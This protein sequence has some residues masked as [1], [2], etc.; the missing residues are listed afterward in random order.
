VSAKPETEK[1]DQ[2]PN[3][4][5]PAVTKGG[6]SAHDVTRL[7]WD[8]KET[9]DP[10]ALGR[11]PSP[12]DQTVAVFSSTEQTIAQPHSS[13]GAGAADSSGPGSGSAPKYG[14]DTSKVTPDGPTVIMAAD[15]GRGA[16]S[17]ADESLVSRSTSSI[18]VGKQTILIP[19]DADKVGPYTI[20]EEIARGGMG[21]V[22][23]VYREEL[24]KIF[25]LKVLLSGENASADSLTRFRREAQAAAKLD[26]HPNIVQVFDA[27]EENDIV[28]FTMD[29]IE[30]CSL[31]DAVRMDD[32]EADH[33]MSPGRAAEIMSQMARA[34]DYAHNADIIHRD[35][36][37][38]N[39]LLDRDYK[40]YLTDF[41]LAKDLDEAGDLTLPGSVLGSPPFMSPEQARGD[42][43][44]IDWRSDIYSLGA[45]LYFALCKKPPFEHDTILQ[46][47][48]AVAED[49]V[50]RLRS[51]VPGLHQDLETI[52]LKAMDREPEGRYET[53]LDFALDLEAFLDGRAISA[54]PIGRF[55]KARRYLQKH[56]ELLAM[57][58]VL[59]AL[60]SALT[61]NHWT[62]KATLE[63]NTEPKGATLFVDGQAV[64]TTPVRDLKLSPGRHELRAVRAGFREVNLGRHD[65]RRSEK[66][67]LKIPLVSSNGTLVV[68][69][70]PSAVQLRIGR[71]DEGGRVRWTKQSQS[72]YFE[73]LP[74][75]SGYIVE[76]FAL[77][78]RTVRSESFTLKYGRE[79]R[80]LTL[81]LPPDHGTLEIEGRPKNAP[82][83]IH[84]I[85]APSAAT[86]SLGHPLGD[87][88]CPP[89]FVTITPL[90][91]SLPLSLP[92]GVYEAVAKSPGRRTRRE[93]LTV[94]YGQKTGLRLDLSTRRLWLTDLG[95]VARGS[96]IVFDVNKDGVL[97]LI[98]G[99]RGASIVVCSG[100]DGRLLK[101]TDRY[102]HESRNARP[103][104]TV[105][106]NNRTAIIAVQGGRI[107]AFDMKSGS[108][109][110]STPHSGLRVHAKVNGAYVLGVTETGRSFL[111]DAWTGRTIS[112]TRHSDLTE[113]GQA[114]IALIGGGQTLPRCV[115]GGQGSRK[116][117]LRL[118]DLN[119]GGE[120]WKRDLFSGK[121]R[122]AYRPPGDGHDEWL[123][124]ASGRKLALIKPGTGEDIVVAFPGETISGLPLIADFTGDKLDDWVFATKS[125]AVRIVYGPD[126]IS[127]KRQV[128]STILFR[129][130]GLP[131][132]DLLAADLDGDGASEVVLSSSD[133]LIYAFKASHNQFHFKIQPFS[134]LSSFVTD[135]KLRGLT[136]QRGRVVGLQKGDF[137]RDGFTD[138]A[139]VSDDGRAGVISG[140][141]GPVAWS[142]RLTGPLAR[143]VRVGDS[144]LVGTETGHF[145]KLSL[146]D[147]RRILENDVLVL[148]SGIEW[149]FADLNQD[150][151]GDAMLCGLRT[152]VLAVSG[153]TG[154]LLWKRSDI[155]PRR[156]L[157]GPTFL[158]SLSSH[159][160]KE[161]LLCVVAAEWGRKSAPPQSLDGHRIK[162]KTPLLILDGSSGRVID[163]LSSVPR[164]FAAPVPLIVNGVQS[165]LLMSGQSMGAVIWSGPKRGRELFK[166]KTWGA[167]STGFRPQVV[168]IAARGERQYLIA[169]DRGLTLFERKNGQE[170]VL[171]K[172][173]VNELQTKPA[174]TDVNRDGV[175]DCLVTDEKGL[176]I[177]LSGKDGV[178]IW[179]RGDAPVSALQLIDDING[180]GVIDFFC[181][182]SG[183]FDKYLRSGFDGSVIYR[184]GPLAVGAGLVHRELQFIPAG[185][186]RE[187]GI[188]LSIQ[189]FDGTHLILLKLPKPS[190]REPQ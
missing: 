38:H 84:R 40:P 68:L 106:K 57:L 6:V 20:L 25:A 21:V 144:L 120:R 164:A 12:T 46:T 143:C 77:G 75:G 119:Q 171:W 30:G 166:V 133:R 151:Y 185:A 2:R 87:R 139:F 8:S 69:T 104:G 122:F 169:G 103:L 108:T 186:G 188:L 112:S 42:V 110:W 74:A 184:F 9:K 170:R 71:L 17:S 16:G 35:I 33:Q 3:K 134:T 102:L 29:Y 32:A 50:P 53:A 136:T 54:V 128:P 24:N 117:N 132:T 126:I 187:R 142:R 81:S 94:R 150:G 149:S 60:A 28:Y 43:D 157:H 152:G 11:L 23:K 140:G 45:T 101:A 172:V 116:P 176:V 141:P 155:T 73:D 34:L 80:D 190:K 160:A 121:V 19:E 173:A 83:F 22:Y 124:A 1:D 178:R 76:A 91:V 109:L 36:K 26:R 154:K 113:P 179:Q 7:D 56:P 181:A 62:K 41:G 15:E 182:G 65:F 96:P 79:R 37:P 89:Q 14:G 118:I 131:V 70:N 135:A 105:S 158:S 180:D 95:P 44:E 162:G 111:L 107:A 78:F 92:T 98:I 67:S 49:E 51:I 47:L 90:P 174:W 10:A 168:D 61:V 66:V 167:A 27:G 153:R 125:G 64:G 86:I 85:G 88:L 183:R 52:C 55:E 165:F 4:S 148:E 93:R 100:D 159:S 130:Q 82:V 48:R 115:V 129:S 63:F 13:T 123:I 114:P 145:M 156:Q 59:V 127:G 137:D 161:S 72:P 39:V 147:G 177:A 5:A 189:R 99:R 146:R 163:V 97:D 138:I 31:A 18:R 58:T 175:K